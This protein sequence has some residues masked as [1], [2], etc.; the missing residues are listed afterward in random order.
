MDY[1]SGFGA[2]P[3]FSLDIASR[4]I[5]LPGKIGINGADVGRYYREGRLDDIRNY[6]EVDV[7]QTSALMLRLFHLT[8]ELSTNGFKKWLRFF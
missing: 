2:S 8:G 1:L 7:I 3:K 4:S 6:C 5:G